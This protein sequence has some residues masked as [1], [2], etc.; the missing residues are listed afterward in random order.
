MSAYL[1]NGIDLFT[2]YG[3]RA[4]HAPDSNIAMKGIYDMPARIGQVSYE[5]AE[6]PIEPWVTADEIFF[7]G[8]DISFHGSIIGTNRQ[9][10]DGLQSLYDAVEAFTTLVVLSTPYGDF[11]V[12]VKTIEPEY[13]VGG[14]YLVINFREPV[15]DLT[16]GLLPGLSTSGYT[17]D[18][19][20]FMSFGLYYSKGS[21]VR[22]LAELKEQLFTKYGSEGY[23]MSKRKN[24][25]FDVNCTLIASGLSDFQDK[26]ENLY[27]LF[28]SENMRTIIINNEIRITSFAASGF[29]IENIY[30]LD[31]SVV[32]T[33]KINLICTMVEY[34]TADST[35][36]TVDSDLIPVDSF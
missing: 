5:W 20:P 1:L 11:N 31:T 18:Q 10:N 9:V 2:A 14:C 32:A 13:H 15:V 27:L 22:S 21:G 30:L 12:Q 6:S 36:V 25:T 17:I 4:G 7:A 24:R 19:I 28:S 34:L 23:Q 8:R 3:V 26:V 29:T 33:F 16:G 35:V